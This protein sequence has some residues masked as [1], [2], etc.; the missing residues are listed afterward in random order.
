MGDSPMSRS[1]ID[2]E[3]RKARFAAVHGDQ[4]LTCS[5]FR[6]WDL[7]PDFMG[8]Y[9]RV[10]PFTLVDHIRCHELW[11]FVSETAK[12]DGDI[13]EVGVWRGGTGCIM[14]ARAQMIGR[15]GEVFLC[16]TF[17]G[18]VKAGA[19]DPNYSGGEHADTDIEIVNQLLADT[20]VHNC[21]ILQGIFPDETGP[22]IASRRFSLCH[23]DVDVYESARD[24]FDW[25][26][27]R[28]SPGGAVVFDD[29]GFRGCIGIT[30][31]AE[32]L[33]A[34]QDLV[35]IHNANGHAILVKTKA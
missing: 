17:R 14:A 34:R 11:N 7:D 4:I 19:S 10:Q 26:W 18:V 32:D 27:P 15:K 1:A 31:L 2:I 24:V 20:N 12:I 22:V 6:A 33:R 9:S 23:I 5:T 21:I 13:L 30:M 8:L 3:A 28:M 16:D 25:V 29:Y 35:F